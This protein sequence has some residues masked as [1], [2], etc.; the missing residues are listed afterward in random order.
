MLYH[1]QNNGLGFTTKH[2]VWEI[3]GWTKEKRQSEDA[4]DAWECLSLGLRAQ[5]SSKPC[6]A[7]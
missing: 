6:T 1:H 3:P 5:N 2:L 7:L 4:Q